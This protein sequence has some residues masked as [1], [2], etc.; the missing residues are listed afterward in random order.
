[1]QNSGRSQALLG[2]LHAVPAGFSCKE[3]AVYK[4]LTAGNGKE[5]SQ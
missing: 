2:S 5:W 1:M 3:R 4:H